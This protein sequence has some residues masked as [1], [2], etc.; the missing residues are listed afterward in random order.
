MAQVD[1]KWRCIVWAWHRQLRCQAVEQADSKPEW[2]EPDHPWP[3][4]L[5]CLHTGLGLG[6][7]R[8]VPRQSPGLG[9]WA[10]HRP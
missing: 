5:S 10:Q 3:R 4:S 9:P 7:V 1:A 2:G 6:S 8:F